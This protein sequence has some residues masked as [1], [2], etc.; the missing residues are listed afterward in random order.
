MANVL[1]NEQHLKN[2]ANSVRNKLGTTEKMLPANMASHIDLISTGSPGAEEALMFFL[3]RIEKIDYDD[4]DNEIV[5]NDDEIEKITKFNWPK[6]LEIIGS[7]A[8]YYSAGLAVTSLPDSVKKIGEKAFYKCKNLA[9]TSLPKNIT[10]IGR[11][12]FFLCENLA[13]T[14]LPKNITEIGESAFEG[15]ENLALTSLPENAE[16]GDYVFWRCKNLAL[17]SLPKNMTKIKRGMF[18]YCTNLALTEL[19]SGITEIGQEAFSSCENLALT[20]LPENLTTIGWGAFQN[21]TNLALTSLPS[22]LT[23]IPEEVFKN[24]TNLALTSIPKNLT[25]IGYRAFAGCTCFTDLVISPDGPEIQPGAF[26]DCNLETVTINGDGN[27]YNY[28]FTNAL[29]GLNMDKLI[30]NGN[31]LNSYDN[32]HLVFWWLQE[33]QIREIIVN[34][35]IGTPSPEEGKE[36]DM[37]FGDCIAEII[38]FNKYVYLDGNRSVANCKNVTTINLKKGF[39]TTGAGFID[40]Y[41]LSTINIY[42][43]EEN[44]TELDSYS[45]QNCP[46]LTTINIIG[47]SNAIE[48]G[49]ISIS[50]EAF[51]GLY[52]NSITINVPWAEGKTPDAPWGAPNATI[53]Y[54]YTF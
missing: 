43:S 28:E 1:I 54:N 30:L 12:A 23:E 38:T 36:E 31:V 25:K 14:S 49:M 32:H 17:K 34:C 48:K 20:S 4:E 19:P 8:F 41:D 11:E 27:D 22:G 9:L 7:H 53:N 37:N 45:L 35:N 33:S 2:I 10:E 3:T 51:S 52:D 46:S 40:C 44:V 18:G 13:L 47:P 15:C 16:F 50:S 42:L 29:G 21:C 5:I 39:K 26:A 24:C 6:D